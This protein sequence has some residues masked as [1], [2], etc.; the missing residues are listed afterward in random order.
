MLWRE[1]IEVYNREWHD[2]SYSLKDIQEM[3]S[4]WYNQHWNREFQEDGAVNSKVIVVIGEIEWRI[5]QTGKEFGFYFNCQ[6]KPLEVLK[7]G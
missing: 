2:D 4:L 3:T 5:P 1:K 6:S 7:R